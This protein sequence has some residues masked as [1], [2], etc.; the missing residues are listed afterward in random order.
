MKLICNSCG[1]EIDDSMPKCPY[2]DTLIVK[3]AEAHY[4]EK[5]YDIQEDLEELNE[6]PMDT[7]R[8]EVKHQWKRMKKAFIAAFIAA[9]ILGGI[10]LLHEKRFERDNMEDYIWGQENFSVMTELYENEQYEQ[11][12]EMFDKA[13]MEDKPVWNWEYYEAY[14]EWRD[15]NEM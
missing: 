15:A 7:V 3:G 9:L 8:K 11:L 5:L 13:L 12:N 6:I 4:M 1:A 14:C 10:F 2:C